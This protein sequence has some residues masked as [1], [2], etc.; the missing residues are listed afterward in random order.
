M[1]GLSEL[2]ELYLYVGTGYFKAFTTRIQKFLGDKVHYAFSSAFSLIPEPQ[3]GDPTNLDAMIGPKRDNEENPSYQRYCPMTCDSITPLQASKDKDSNSTTNTKS[4][5][6]I[7]GI[8][9]VYQDGKGNNITVVYKGASADKLTHTVRLQNGT[10]MDV[11]D[12][13]LQLLD[14]PDFLNTPKTPLDFRNEVRHGLSL[15][16]A[17]ALA[18]PQ[19]LLP[20]QQELIS[21][22]H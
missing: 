13:N 22:H 14:Q 6:F 5:D 8:D 15:E 1:H 11:Y 4:F 18:R 10:K 19:P 9:L 7:L 20:L 3:I 12:S 2:P 21:W 17:Q 16:E